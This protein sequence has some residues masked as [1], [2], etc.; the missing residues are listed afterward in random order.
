MPT[1]PSRDGSSRAVCQP[2]LEPAVPG[3]GRQEEAPPD[4]QHNQ[5]I[6]A[7]QRHL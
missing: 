5:R 3:R 2:G 1:S 7:T 4:T 6:L